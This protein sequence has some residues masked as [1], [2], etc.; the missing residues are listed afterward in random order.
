M[1]D[2]N[3]AARVRAEATAKR[4]REAAKR[5][6]EA[7]GAGPSQYE[8][9]GVI[10]QVG[11]DI[12]MGDNTLQVARKSQP[13]GYGG[14]IPMTAI[15]LPTSKAKVAS[16]SLNASSTKQDDGDS[17][18]LPGWKAT[19]DKESGDVYY[20]NKATKETS[21]DKPSIMKSKPEKGVTPLPY[22]WEEVQDPLSSDVYYWNIHTQKTQWERPVSLEQAIEA[23]SKLDNLL[24]FCGSTA[25]FPQ[26]DETS[27]GKTSVVSTSPSSSILYPSN[28]RHEATAISG[29]I[30]CTHV[31]QVDSPRV[32]ALSTAAVHI[33]A[34]RRF[35]R[36]VNAPLKRLSA[37]LKKV[38][39]KH[40]IKR[41][42]F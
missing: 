33:S 30:A 29:S 39:Y 36:F 35:A 42:D 41:C 12:N 34:R 8:L 11:Y 2:R 1:A 32:A 38:E 13:Q 10:R 37:F 7:S 23:K 9:K 26:D 3:A 22:G 15:P 40:Q 4:D 14:N 18:L 27:R 17:D 5:H 28:F 6:L 21:W 16:S 19:V 31:V 24:Q 25:M 20:W